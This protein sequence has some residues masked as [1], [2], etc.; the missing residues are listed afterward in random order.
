MPNVRRSWRRASGIE[1]PFAGNENIFTTLADKPT[2][3]EL[4]AELG[5]RFDV[6]NTAIKKWSVGS[7]LQ[8]VLDSV[9]VLLDEPAVRN[10]NI[11]RIAGGDEMIEARCS[12]RVVYATDTV[13]RVR[14]W[15]ATAMAGARGSGS[16]L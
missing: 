4:A 1:D 14:S 8:S 12:G 6:F 5:T 11:T 2:P 10:G 7:P 16:A 15:P 13:R 9:T 3:G